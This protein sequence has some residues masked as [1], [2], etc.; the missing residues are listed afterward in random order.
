[1]ALFR[2]FRGNRTTLDTRE[3]H[4]GYAY[5]CTDD[6]TFHIDYVDTDGNLQ[7]KQINAKYAEALTGYKISTIL[8]SSDLEIPTSKAVVDA[9]T[10][11]TDN[12]TADDLG[13]YVQDTEPT[14]AADGDIWVDT[15]NDPSF[16]MPTVPEVTAADNGKVLMVVNGTWQAVT[17][18]MSVDANG[19]LTV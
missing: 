15:A 12:I 19:V 11:A 5:F 17:L 4:D 14:D 16:I 1:M 6:G 10:T 3:L 13:V 8:N 9:I 7:R 18:N 2:P